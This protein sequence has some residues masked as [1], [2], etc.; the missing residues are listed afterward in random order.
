LEDGG[1]AH[2]CKEDTDD[3]WPRARDVLNRGP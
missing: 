2:P 3:G 1:E